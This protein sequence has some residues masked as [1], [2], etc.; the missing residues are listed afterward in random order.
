[1]P[2]KK[3]PEPVYIFAGEETLLMEE[4]ISRIKKSMGEE[5]LMNFSSFN[6]EQIQDINRV[7][8][9]INTLPFLSE[10]KCL[11]I[12]RV[13]KL[14]AKPLSKIIEYT[15]TPCRSTVLV[16]TIEAPPKD[17]AANAV[18]NKFP[19]TVEVRRFNPMK[20]VVLTSW[21]EKKAG[22]M[23][24]EIRKD[25]S[26]LLADLTDRNTALMAQEI[27][28]LCI[29]IQEDRVIEKKHVKEL[30]VPGHESSIFNLSDS[31]FARNKQAL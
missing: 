12:K 1:M 21:L 9:Q 8:E 29:Y 24:K 18:L 4:Q 20:T 25:A 27:K 7:I 17:K 11:I 28:K 2:V 13:N 10:R 30:V 16:L 3:T 14:K 22:E 23:G 19:K 15:K 26:F 31:L 5:A 6:A